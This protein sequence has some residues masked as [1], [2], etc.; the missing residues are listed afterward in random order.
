MNHVSTDTVNA[1]EM[2]IYAGGY[3]MRIV[4]IGILAVIL[5][6]ILIFIGQNGAF[7]G[8]LNGGGDGEAR[9]F[10]DQ[11]A[12]VL[13]NFDIDGS[14][15][16]AAPDSTDSPIILSGLPSYAGLKFILPVDARP[17]SGDLNLAFTSLV[18]ED[19][20][21]VLRVSINGVK[22]ADYLLNSGNQMD[23]LQVQ[24][25]PRDLAAGTI[26]VSLSLQ[27]RGA[28]TECTIDDAIAAV[29]N[30]DSK[31]GLRLNLSGEPT[32]A[33]DQLALWG[34]RVPIEWSQSNGN[35]VNIV[36]QAAILQSKGYRPIFAKDGVA[37]DALTKVA[38]SAKRKNPLSIPAT[39]PIA[40][41]SDS[42]NSGL[43]KFTRRVNWRYAYD[44]NDLPN[45]Q[46]PTA[47]D[48]RMQIG[49]VQSKIERD[50]V[51]S[52]NDKLL[53][54]K[55][56]DSNAE[57]FNQSIF[58][59]AAA[60]SQKNIIDITMQAYDADNLR[61]GDIA[62]SIAELLPETTLRNGQISL[63]NDLEKL[64]SILSNKGNLALNIEGLS[65]PD[66]N[67]AAYLLS[68]LSPNSWKLNQSANS[69]ITVLTDSSKLSQYASSN[70]Q[71]W[72]V[73]REEGSG[74]K[75]NAVAIDKA[76]LPSIGGVLLL[77][78]TG[79]AAIVAPLVAN[80][81]SA[82]TPAGQ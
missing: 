82:V 47:L 2:K 57:R 26:N 20:E 46:L 29:V 7:D 68:E 58:I 17:T 73:Y 33:R 50:V 60:H 55:R 9:R 51:V 64:K 81:A 32:S 53:F 59:P 30:I 34:N 77:V 67:E 24:L 43:R 42:S 49:P 5:I 72:L 11:N 8:A 21:G 35:A 39:Y 4:G 28:I 63:S 31:S 44:V 16:F 41:T 6:G 54:S 12:S 25:T 27:G 40:I 74:A 66:A 13:E 23:E 62:Q 61:C 22:R 10:E 18:A 65:S 37:L 79:K 19:V 48:L 14:T 76:N 75:I 38:K 52:I 3:A 78:D 36:R 15:V 1:D 71:Q 69:K 80:T 45:K 70:N 56:L